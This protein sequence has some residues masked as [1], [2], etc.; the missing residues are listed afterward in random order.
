[1]QIPRGPN[2]LIR[3]FFFS[4]LFFIFYV[5]ESLDKGCICGGY[6]RFNEQLLFATRGLTA[7]WR[8]FWYD[9]CIT[10]CSVGFL[11]YPGL[12]FLFWRRGEESHLRYGDYGV[13]VIS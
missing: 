6:L 2:P 13:F 8:A 3:R 10:S 9:C 4:L 5:P 7:S 11:V 12:K 1:M